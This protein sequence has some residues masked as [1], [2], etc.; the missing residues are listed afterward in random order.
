MQCQM[1]LKISSSKSLKLTSKY[2]YSQRKKKNLGITQFSN[3]LSLENITQVV[4]CVK[5]SDS[6]VYNRILYF[7]NKISML[8]SIFTRYHHLLPC[9]LNIF[10]IQFLFHCW[11][12]LLAIP[13][14]VGNANI[15]NTSML[16]AACGSQMN[17]SS[18]LP[19]L[20]QRNGENDALPGEL[21]SLV[22]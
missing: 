15:W 4:L 16:I 7:W 11:A 18:N 9:G 22:T 1:L 3:I 12:M 6:L 20:L 21:M 13:S 8:W 19:L 17:L 2:Q 14:A 5:Y 10:T